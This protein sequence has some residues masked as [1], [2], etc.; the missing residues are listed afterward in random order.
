MITTAHSSCNILADL[1]IAHGVT[2]AV[3]SP[4]SRNAPLVIAISRR[5]EMKCHVVIDERSA[6][7]IALG[8]AIQSGHPVAIVCTSGSA[9]LNYAPAVAEA[10]YR[11]VPLVVISADRP[12]EW[13]D[14]DD[15]QTIWQQDALSR[16]VKRSTDIPAHTDFMAGAWW[17]DRAINDVLLEALNGR[18][19]PVHINMRIDAPLNTFTE[20]QQGSSRVIRMVTPPSSLP[21]NEIRAMAEPLR[22]PHRVMIVAGFHQPDHKLNKALVK[23]ASQPNVVVLTETIANVHSPFFITRIDSTLCRLTPQERE[24]LRPDT[25]ITLGG[26]LVS[27]HIKEWLRSLPDVDHWHIGISHTTVDCFKHLTARVNMEAAP[28][29][30]QLATTMQYINARNTA[31]IPVAHSYSRQWREAASRAVET[32]DRYIASAPWST[33]TAFSTIISSLGTNVNLHLSNGTSV[34]YAQLMDC[35]RLHRCECNRGVSGIDGCTSTALGASLAYQGG[36][37]LLVSGDMS[38]QYDIAALSSVLMN[39]RLKMIVICNK[40]GEIFRF[41]G[42]TSALPERERYFAVGTRLPLR[43]LCDGYGIDYYEASS[44]EELSALI[45]RFLKSSTSPAILA[46]NTP[47]EESARVLR[48]YFNA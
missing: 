6:A 9:L 7:F 47:A 8:M 30:S 35:S 34:R 16:Y 12:E 2:Q 17:V 32:H 40:G 25:V 14:Q 36:P 24:R 22:S 31:A 37:T 4:G 46:I 43:Q 27:R 18:P 26:A 1:L 5:E 44:R 19:G 28:F 13:I 29:M 3:L 10:F 21:V 45:P 48:D 11:H 23:L 33:L 38:F 15:S 42:V 20:W 41:I 39:P